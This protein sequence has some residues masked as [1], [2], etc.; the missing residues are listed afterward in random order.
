MLGKALP[1]GTFLK[2][3]PPSLTS[4]QLD[5]QPSALGPLAL[6]CSPP[7]APPALLGAA[8]AQPADYLVGKSSERFRPVLHQQAG[9]LPQKRDDCASMKHLLESHSPQVD[10]VRA[11][12]LRHLVFRRGWEEAVL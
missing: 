1:S 8:A 2:G 10:A 11:M 3:F 7:R 4:L 5:T 12:I 9:Q 6:L